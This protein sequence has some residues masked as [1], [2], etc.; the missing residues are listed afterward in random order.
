MSSSSVVR[1]GLLAAEISDRRHV[2]R[3][4]KAQTRQVLLGE[5]CSTP[6]T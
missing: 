3:A 4:V 2:L 1:R 5:S 6:F